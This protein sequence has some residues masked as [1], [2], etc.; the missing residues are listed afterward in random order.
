MSEGVT[1][2]RSEAR[3]NHGHR[4]LELSEAEESGPIDASTARD[5][6]GIVIGDAACSEQQQFFFR[7]H[8]REASR[9]PVRDRNRAVVVAR[10]RNGGHAARISVWSHVGKP[11]IDCRAP[12]TRR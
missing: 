4:T 5:A 2:E 11:I 1:N 12:G 8:D 10:P 6:N 7:P 3:E 9:Q